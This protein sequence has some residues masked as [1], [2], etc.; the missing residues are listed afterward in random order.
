M[1]TDSLIR[2]NADATNA[3]DFSQPLKVIAG[4]GLF[5]QLH[6]TVF[7]A[8][9]QHFGIRNAILLI[10]INSQ[11]NIIT[12]CSTNRFNTLNISPYIPANFY[13]Q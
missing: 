13:L 3:T 5:K 7:Y 4:H 9:T 8:L 11:R 12:N 1:I 6:L 2:H 10:S